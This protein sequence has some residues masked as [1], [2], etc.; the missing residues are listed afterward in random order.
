MNTH[1]EEFIPLNFQRRGGQHVAVTQAPKHD[2]TLITALGRALWWQSLIELGH[3]QSVT[4]L[5]AAEGRTEATVRAVIKLSLLAPDLVEEILAGY[6]PRQLTLLWF[7]RNTL[8]VEWTE[9][10]DLFA[11]FREVG[12]RE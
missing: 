4:E 10:R 2:V 11:R 7:Q 8:P 1:L 3:Y 9:Q 5:A 12:V 6:Q